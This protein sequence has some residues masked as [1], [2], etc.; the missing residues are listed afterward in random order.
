MT[1]NESIE[2][3]ADACRT[4]LP[5]LFP[6]DVGL[7]LGSGLGASA[8]RFLREGA[9]AISYAEIPGMPMTHVSGHAGRL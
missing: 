7:I 9:R 6:I 3:A 2:I 5:G 8:D 4:A 1:Q